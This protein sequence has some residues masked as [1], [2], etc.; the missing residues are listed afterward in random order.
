MY[1]TF[2]MPEEYGGQCASES[3]VLVEDELIPSDEGPI[4]N[5]YYQWIPIYL[6]FL[7]LLFLIPKIVWTTCEGGVMKFVRKGTNESYKEKRDKLLNVSSHIKITE[8]EVKSNILL[9]CR[10]SK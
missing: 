2:H 4:Y 3:M 8:L 10:V 9:S 6:S 5:S 7:A 1:A